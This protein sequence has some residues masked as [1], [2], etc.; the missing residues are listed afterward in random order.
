[1][2]ASD[3]VR[4][5]GL[6]IGSTTTS[7]LVTQAR[8]L[9][10]SVTGRMELG[11]ATAIHRFE[12]VFTPFCGEELD[13]DALESLV[14]D[15]IRRGGVDSSQLFAGG[16]II[17]G[18][19]AAAGNAR[20]VSELV[21][22]TFAEAL[23][24]TADDPRL[25]SWLAFLGNCLELS[26]ADPSTPVLNLDIGGGTTNPAW[27]LAG[28]VQHVGCYAIGARHVRVV[29][30]TWQIAGLSPLAARLFQHL[31]IARHVGDVLLPDEVE[32]ILDFY[33]TTL[34]AVVRGDAEFL[35]QEHVRWHEQVPFEPPRG[36]KP[37]ITFSG[38]V[39]ELVYRGARRKPL[40]STTAFGDLG[41]DLAR[42]ICQS[43]LLA[44]DLLTCMPASLGR[45][46]VC[47]LALHTAELSGTTL[48]LPQPEL[49]PQPDLPIV[50]R[51]SGDA[52]EAQ[53]QR[54][55]D[56]AKSGGRG[57][58]L[59]V[60]GPLQGWQAVK[61]LGEKLA[62]AIQHA[63]YP[64]DRPLVLLVG[65]N[66]GQALGAYATAWGRSAVN[67][68]VI[69]ELPPRRARFVSLGKL[70][71]NVVPVSYYGLCDWGGKR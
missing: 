33:V 20:V 22:A 8:V 45:A 25:E 27:G 21:R 52:D 71:N 6:D 40:P 53:L 39:G 48:Y 50:G 58:C 35:S 66:I 62:S 13:Q 4:L 42:R 14:T 17:T 2:P 10:N 54:L 31:G 41:I 9:R 60:D 61:L 11:P 51:F 55:I 57:A 26:R 18:L 38:G 3:A 47:G 30:G 16:A 69:D 1:M 5:F 68:I 56:L 28:E 32:A 7:A 65:Q 34:E 46:T 15:W 24:V 44:A 43:P 23:V 59:Q 67:L 36:F 37:I 70:S 64:R 49:L 12:P 29:P 19:A 63:D